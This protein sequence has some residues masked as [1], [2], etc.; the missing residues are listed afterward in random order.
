MDHERIR[1]GSR[2]AD[3]ASTVPA[4][5]HGRGTSPGTRRAYAA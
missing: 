4:H 3:P 2:P 5:R 1:R